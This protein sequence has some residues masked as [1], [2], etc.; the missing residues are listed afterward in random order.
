MSKI[1]I[2]YGYR[3]VT[4]SK[5]FKQSSSECGQSTHMGFIRQRNTVSD[6][7]ES[8]HFCCKICMDYSFWIM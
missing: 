7:R 1:K 2:C 6:L 3:K 8:C 4:S 5:N